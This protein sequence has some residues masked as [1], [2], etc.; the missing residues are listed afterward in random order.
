M[1]FFLWG[2]GRTERFAIDIINFEDLVHFV[3]PNKPRATDSPLL[4]APSKPS[5]P[6]HVL[7]L[8]HGWSPTV[9][10]NY[11]IIR[12]LTW[13]AENAGWQ[14]IVPNFIPSYKMGSLRGRAERVNLVYQ[15]MLCLPEKPVRLVMCG[16][17]QGGC[18]AALACTDRVVEANNIHGLLMIGSESPLEMDGMNWV[19]RVPHIKVIH[20]QNDAVIS[21]NMI[22][23]VAERWHVPLVMLDSKVEIGS[24][25]YNDDDIG[26]DFLAKDLVEP[27]TNLFIEFLSECERH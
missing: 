6:G 22:K 20:A 1:M 23:Q 2:S 25:H 18:V 12:T 10:P 21:P 15:E 9:G 3:D 27:L 24:P 4:S 19:P 14:V 11:P 7:I 26:H 17:S 8:S 13:L 16:H 5:L